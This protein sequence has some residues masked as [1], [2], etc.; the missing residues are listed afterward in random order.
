MVG[1][2]EAERI[3]EQRCRVDSLVALRGRRVGITTDRALR[4]RG[5]LMKKNAN[6]PSDR[7]A[8]EMCKT[9]PWSPC[10]RSPI[11]SRRGSRESAELQRLGESYVW[12]FSKNR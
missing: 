4:A 8:T 6:G 9:Y 3:Q 10:T 11:G 5:K 12:Y 7:L 1:R 2:R